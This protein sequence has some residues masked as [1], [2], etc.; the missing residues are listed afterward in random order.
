[1]PSNSTSLPSAP[2]VNLGDNIVLQPPLSRCG[3][4]P[5]LVLIRSANVAEC[6]SKNTSLDP[7]PL[8]KWAEESYAVAQITFDLDS[9]ANASLLS[10]RVDSAIAGLI[11]LPECNNK[12]KFGILGLY[13]PSSKLS[14]THTNVD[15]SLWLPIRLRPNIHPLTAGPHQWHK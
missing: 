11:A 15:L 13:S 3:Q 7:E 10:V 9:S 2:R 1:M 14:V 8:Q 4:G 12:E 6:Q 5:G